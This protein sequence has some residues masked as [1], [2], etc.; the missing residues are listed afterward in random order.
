MI[1]PKYFCAAFF[2]S[3]LGIICSGTTSGQTQLEYSGNM[4]VV[5]S[6][7]EQTILIDALHTFYKTTYSY[8]SKLESGELIA[9]KPDFSLITHWHGDHFSAALHRE[10]LQA[11]PGA[12]IAGSGQVCDSIGGQSKQLLRLSAKA[13][14]STII[15]DTEEL[16]IT[17]IPIPHVNERFRTSVEHF[18]FLVQTG[19]RRILHLGDAAPHAGLFGQLLRQ[20]PDIDVLIC[21]AWF[22][23]YESGLRIIRQAQP[24]QL[25]VTHIPNGEEQEYSKQFDTPAQPTVF[26]THKGQKVSL[27]E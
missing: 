2:L 27:M 10:L 19:D 24:G 15:Y 25:I 26:F 14:E 18:G 6:T 4:G 22:V 23:V 7:G 13:T 3:L 5:I 20:Y 1:L 16:Q 9:R 8:P 21:P 11:Q 17:A 12:V